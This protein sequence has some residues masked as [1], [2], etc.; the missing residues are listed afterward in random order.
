MKIHRDQRATWLCAKIRPPERSLG[1]PRWLR[2]LLARRGDYALR[3]ASCQRGSP[4][5]HGHCRG[6]LWPL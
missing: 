3:C 5:D 6:P 1:E 4:S 2:R